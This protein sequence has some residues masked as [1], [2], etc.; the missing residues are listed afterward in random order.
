MRKSNKPYTKE[1]IENAVKNS[2]SYSDIYR[3]LGIPINGGSYRWIKS[4]IA[5]F[6]IDTSHFM[7]LQERCK[8]MGE[9][10][11][12]NKNNQLYSSEDLSN[13]ERIGA[14]K[15]RN[16]MKYHGF[17]EVCNVCK[18][19][20]W[21]G[22]PI[23]LDIDHIDGDGTNN[24]INNIQF[25]CPNCHRQKTIKFETPLLFGKEEKIKL[26]TKT[27]NKN[28]TSKLCPNCSKKIN[29]S[30]KQ[31]MSCAKIG[32]FKIEW[33]DKDVLEKLLWEKPTVQIG[34]ELGVSDKAI[35]KHIKK[36]GLT[37]PPRGYWAKLNSQND[38]NK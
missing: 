9:I 3:S 5:K 38:Q 18:L 13:G 20:D 27:Y 22:N 2:I 15:L 10:A 19:K 30:S 11:N 31:C 21:L 23:R 4:L 1:Q 25:L 37:K 24:N 28:R 29:R 17:V 8:R 7:T 33:P 26:A 16:F 35:E 14:S 34:K 12:R 32:L 36:L 6:C